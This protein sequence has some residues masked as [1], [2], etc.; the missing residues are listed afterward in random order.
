MRSPL[1]HQ[2]PP[3]AADGASAGQLLT[4]ATQAL[5]T[6]RLAEVDELNLAIQWAVMN[7]HPRDERDPMVT[8]GGDGTPDVRE[9]AIPELAMA[10]ETHPATTRALIA[11]GLDLV[12]RLPRTWAVVQAGECEPW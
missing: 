9:H 2:E 11:D 4:L 12:H 3:Q 7:G 5:T 8:P 6:R 1:T 10:R